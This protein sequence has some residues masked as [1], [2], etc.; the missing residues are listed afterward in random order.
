MYISGGSNIYPREIE[1]KVLTHEAVSEVAVVG[2]PDPKWGEVGV[3]VC[4]LREG[5]QLDEAAMLDW[6]AS[7]V[8]RYKLPK[9][10]FF[11]DALPKSGYGKIVK[12]TIRERLLGDGWTAERATTG[13]VR[14]PAVVGGVR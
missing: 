3:A 2:V 14:P 5:A 6:M 11:W 10:V 13:S 1:E 12:R 9:R 7:R 4:V 8:A